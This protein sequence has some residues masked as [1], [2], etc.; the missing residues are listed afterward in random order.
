MILLPSP[1]D[2]ERTPAGEMANCFLALRR[3]VQAARTTRDRF[4]FCALDRRVA[5]RTLRGEFDL[6]RCRL[7]P[8]LDDDLDHF[9]NDIARAADDDGV[10]DAHV[11]ATHFVHVVQRRVADSHAADEHRLQPRD[12]RQRASPPDLEFHA[13]DDRVLFV[14]RKLVRYRPARRARYEPKVALLDEAIDLV[15]DA[16]DLVRQAGALRTDV[17]VILQAAFRALHDLEQRRDL[18]APLPQLLQSLAVPCRQ[19]PA[20][21]LADAIEE[22]VERPVGGEPRIELADAAGGSVTRIDERPLAALLAR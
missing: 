15:D 13:F 20:I 22:H 6:R 12:G 8:S 2:V 11:F 10:A 3:A 1:V 9:R 18:Q 16:V 17:T 5:D 19:L 7:G 21:R 14:R 4:P